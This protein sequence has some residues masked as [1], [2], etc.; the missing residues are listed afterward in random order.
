[1]FRKK[2]CFRAAAFLLAQKR[3]QMTKIVFYEKPGCA[4]NARQKQ[5]LAAAGHELYVKNLL[6]EPWTAER[7]RG[8]FGMRP[9]AE[10]FNKAAP[11]IKSGVIDP[12][13]LEAEEA[14]SLMLSA[15]ILIR[16]PLM[17]ADGQKDIGF[18]IEKVDAW[19]GLQAKNTVLDLET[20]R[21]SPP[22]L[23]SPGIAGKE[24]AE[25]AAQAGVAFEAAQKDPCL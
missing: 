18:D 6:A 14:L 3:S 11:Q 1:M 19:I 9:V 7:L 15:P 4:N 5:I 10:W 21:R 2:I 25:N 16:R 23:E 8:F 17:E 13:A 22:R 12:S 20:C 24:E